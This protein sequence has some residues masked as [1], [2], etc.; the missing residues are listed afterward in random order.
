M[1]SSELYSWLTGIYVDIDFVIESIGRAGAVVFLLAIILLLLRS[2]CWNLSN[3]LLGT[4]FAIRLSS[5]SYSFVRFMMGLPPQRLHVSFYVLI[6]F[7]EVLCIVVMYMEQ[8]AVIRARRAYERCMRERAL[9]GDTSK[10]CS[11]V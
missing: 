5:I 4:V 2:S 9:T 3:A 7:F 8:N 11:G 10:D 1:D 6:T